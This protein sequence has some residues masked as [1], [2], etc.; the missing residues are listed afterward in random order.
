VIPFVVPGGVL[1]GVVTGVR[2]TASDTIVLADGATG[3]IT[4]QI[5][6]GLEYV[7]P[8]GSGTK[9]ALFDGT[10]SVD[11]PTRAYRTTLLSVDL[12]SGSIERLTSPMI[13]WTGYTCFGDQAGLIVCNGSQ[14]LRTTEILGIDD[15]T[16]KRIWSYTEKQRVV[17][18]V[19]AAF[20]GVVYAQIAA[21]PVL[22]DAR[23]G[24][25]LPGATPTPSAVTSAGSALSLFDNKLQSPTAI[26]PYGG[27]Y[28]QDATGVAGYDFERI[29]IAL[30]PTA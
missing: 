8:A 20:H 18:R 11:S 3:K 22:L 21:Q 26:T 2:K 28:L 19:T 12:V 9:R 13:H 6:I 14:D 1:N 5:R 24:K 4:K 17:P 23:T 25:A 15:R 29:L 7:R 16:G 30:E 27:I 10:E